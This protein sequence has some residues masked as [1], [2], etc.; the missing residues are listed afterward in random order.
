MRKRLKP[1]PCGPSALVTKLG[2]KTSKCSWMYSWI[3][4][5]RIINAWAQQY[6]RN[7][8]PNDHQLFSIEV[9]LVTT[10]DKCFGND[11]PFWAGEVLC[12]ISLTGVSAKIKSHQGESRVSHSYS[13]QRA[14]RTFRC[15]LRTHRVNYIA[16][17][18]AISQSIT[19][20]KGGSDL[21]P[22]KQKATEQQAV[23]I[24]AKL[25]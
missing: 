8:C 11:P 10:H 4:F 3:S 17:I 24:T 12:H 14:E 1:K 15:T 7:K 19:S 20:I 13:E 25:S 23:R 16:L 6:G 2:E 5:P 22:V 18:R 21:L 9:L